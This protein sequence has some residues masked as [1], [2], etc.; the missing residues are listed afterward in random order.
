M[1]KLVFNV[2]LSDQQGKKLQIPILT[3]GMGFLKYCVESREPLTQEQSLLHCGGI[4]CSSSR[5]QQLDK[6]LLYNYNFTAQ[7]GLVK[8]KLLMISEPVAY[9]VLGQQPIN[10]S[11]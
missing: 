7:L 8:L 2:I 4:L 9:A 5:Q 3:V 6:E 11:F 1:K 10:K